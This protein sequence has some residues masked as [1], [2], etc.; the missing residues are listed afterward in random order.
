MNDIEKKEN[1]PIIIQGDTTLVVTA[2]VE[3]KTSLTEAL[4]E[5]KKEVY[6]QKLSKDDEEPKEGNTVVEILKGQLEELSEVNSL[7]LKRSKTKG[8]ISEEVAF[9]KVVNSSIIELG[10]LLKDEWDI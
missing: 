1:A 5:L 3:E 9:L 7:F 2:T 6:P 4:R 10:K 8:I